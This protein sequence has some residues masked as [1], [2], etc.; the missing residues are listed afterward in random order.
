MPDE[1]SPVTEQMIKQRLVDSFYYPLVSIWGDYT[2]Q[3]KRWKQ[4]T[5][6]SQLPDA[7]SKQEL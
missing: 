7:S 5:V 2:P 3:R 4:G 1:L 6:I